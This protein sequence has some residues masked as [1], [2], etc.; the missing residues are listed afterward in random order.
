M[1]KKG[2]EEN[3]NS[4]ST[5]RGKLSWAV[6]LFTLFVVLISIIAFV[7][8]ALLISEMG[9]VNEIENIGLEGLYKINPYEIGYWAVPLFVVNI[10]VFTIF[11]IYRWNKLPSSIKHALES[12]FSFDPLLSSTTFIKS[13]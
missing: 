1:S 3:S 13:L 11:V 12:F 8:P 7:F 9:S 2:L 10:I 5:K 4:N 6:F